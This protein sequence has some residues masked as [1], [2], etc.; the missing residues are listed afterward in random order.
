MASDDASRPGASPTHSAS[1]P[2]SPTSPVSITGPP[3][4]SGLPPSR[5]SAAHT[6]ISQTVAITPSL[7]GPRSSQAPSAPPSH[8]LGNDTASRPTTS[9][10]RSHVASLR[11]PAFLNPM[12]SQRLQAHRGQWPSSPPLGQ[13][14]PSPFDNDDHARNPLPRD[15]S[16]T[17]TTTK[18]R[19]AAAG[20]L[21]TQYFEDEATVPTASRESVETE[22]TEQHHDV[23]T[24]TTATNSG[25]IN[26]NMRHDAAQSVDT[27]NNTNEA[28]KSASLGT[29]EHESGQEQAARGRSPRDLV[30]A[31]RGRGGEDF[32][33]ASGREKLSSFDSNSSKKRAPSTQK[34]ATTGAQSDKKFIGKNWEYFEGHTLFFLG[35]RFQTAKDR[36]IVLLTAFAV[37]FPSVLF[38]IFGYV[39]KRPACDLY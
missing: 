10:S 1:N 5:P 26:T 36:P 7:T 33:G 28:Q 13:T 16:E 15:S 22:R 9:G 21:H 38:Y 27:F 35:G 34:T 25:L 37:V 18:E 32:R 19:A 30:A 31:F 11:S 4:E 24:A 39:P 20:G 2:T 29:K 6:A 12:S 17:A 14:R 8:S 3:G 23:N